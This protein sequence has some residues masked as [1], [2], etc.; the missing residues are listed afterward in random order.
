MTSTSQ[1]V[2]RGA[3]WMYGYRWLDRLLGFLSI[4]VLAR[5]LDAEAFGLVA[6]AASVVA[7]I[8]GLSDFDVNKA[9]IRIQDESR[10]LYDTAWTLSFARGLLTALIMV[11]V[12]PWVE[13]QRIG[14]ILY[15]LAVVPLL[16]GVANPRFVTFERDLIY[17]RLAIVTLAAKLASFAVTL[18]VA[19]AYETYWALVLG[20][21]ANSLVTT[22]LTYAVKPYMPRPSLAKWSAIF[23][24]SGWMSLATM[25]TTLS[26]QTDRIIIGKLL[27]IAEAGSYY[28][29]QRVGALPTSELISPLQ[30]ILFPSF[31][32]LV[33]DASR[34][35]R[36]VLESVNVLGSLSLPAGVGF[37]L[38]ANDLVPIMLGDEWRPIVP[39]LWVLVPYLGF[40]ATLSMALP[41]V[42]ALGQT[43]LMF[44]V[45]VVY[46]FVHLPLFI[47]GTAKYGL[48][49]SIGAIVLA[50]VFYTYLNTWLLHATVKIRLSEILG[51]LMRPFLGVV[52][53]TGAIFL[54]DLS[55]LELFSSSGSWLSLAVKVSLGATAFIGTVAVLWRAQGRPRGVERRVLE[56]LRIS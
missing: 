41:C 50:G 51:Q 8:E 6:I 40:R 35:R 26:M 45:S 39:L 49:G 38:V 54:A 20:I 2:A 37:G 11:S 32:G 17:S 53:M 3:T 7:I 13:D 23:S 47:A 42:M 30:R 28:V 56:A 4:V 46:A 33:H 55:S 15:V 1:R 14:E 10:E 29:T 31:S 24:F 27:G 21:V 5:I 52:A 25:V 44:R 22:V 9:L 18:Y 19:F 48:P 36:A 12:A 43:Q 34:L 16:G